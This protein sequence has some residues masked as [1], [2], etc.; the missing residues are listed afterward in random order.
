LR[1]VAFGAQSAFDLHAELQ[2]FVPQPKGKQDFAAGVEHVPAPSHVDP[3]VKVIV[4]VGHVEPLQ[5]VPAAYFWQAPATQ[6]PFVPHE[7]PPWSTQRAFGSTVP[8]ATFVHVPS[9]AGRLHDLHEA[10]HVVTQH[11]PCAQTFDAHSVPA[12]QLA[13][14]FLR[15]HELTLQTLGEMQFV[16]TVHDEKHFEPLHAYGAHG[17]DDGATH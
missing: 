5:G 13:P 14:G 2:T 10:L 17:S 4:P 7:V 9:D 6:R 12:E 8:V 3:A 1:H 15:P 11:T 16:V